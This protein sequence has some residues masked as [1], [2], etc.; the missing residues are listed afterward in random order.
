MTELKFKTSLKCGGC[1]DK[2]TPGMN[3]L[4]EV[5]SWEVDLTAT[6]KILTAKAPEEAAAKIIATVEKEGFEIERI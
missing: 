6:P 1:K 4:S 2:I 3:A 5:E